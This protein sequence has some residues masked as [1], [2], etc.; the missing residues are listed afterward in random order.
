MSLELFRS[1]DHVVV[2]WSRG[3]GDSPMDVRLARIGIKRKCRVHVPTLS[4]LPGIVEATDL[5]ASMSQRVGRRI[6]KN[7][8]VDVH[9]A[10]FD[11]GPVTLYLVWHNRFDSDP[12][13]VWLRNAFKHV[14]DSI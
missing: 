4:A 12:G 8:A 13:H 7:W 5:F 3:R 2:S 9:T 10:P 1:A 14:C 6:Q 11:I